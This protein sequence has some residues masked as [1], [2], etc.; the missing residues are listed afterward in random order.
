MTTVNIGPHTKYMPKGP[1]FLRHATEI[2]E[3][4][5]TEETLNIQ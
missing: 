2:I 1:L 4:K 5:D 3:P